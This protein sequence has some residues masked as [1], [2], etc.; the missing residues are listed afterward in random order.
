MKEMIVCDNVHLPPA[1]DIQTLSPANVSQSTS[2]SSS[3]TEGDG[4]GTAVNEHATLDEGTSDTSSPVTLTINNT[5]EVYESMYSARE[6]WRSI[7]GIFGISESTLDNIDSE[8]RSNEDKLRKVIIEWLKGNGRNKTLTWSQVVMALRNKTVA[9]EDLAQEVLQLHSQPGLECATVQSESA[10]S[11]PDN[12]KTT[13]VAHKP[14]T[15]LS[16]RGEF[17]VFF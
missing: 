13:A 17:M 2:S 9:R 3:V 8:N 12:A 16:P 11:L 10:S 7:G 4:A 6:K 5:Q 15:A 1:T 14:T